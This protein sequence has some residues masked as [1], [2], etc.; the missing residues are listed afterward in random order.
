MYKGTD[1]VQDGYLLNQ[2]IIQITAAV[3][4][5]IRKTTDPHLVSV[6]NDVKIKC[7]NRLVVIYD[8]DQLLSEIN[9]I[10]YYYP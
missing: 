7:Y 1:A 8:H 3:K 2:R 10:S 5:S 9:C 4:N 6:I